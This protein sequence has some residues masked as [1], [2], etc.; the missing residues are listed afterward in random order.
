[1]DVKRV[2]LLSVTITFFALCFVGIVMQVLAMSQLYFAYKITSTIKIA[3]PETIEPQALSVCTRYTDVIDFDKLNNETGRNWNYT[4]YHVD[5]K[6]YQKELTIAEIMRYTPSKMLKET[7]FRTSGSYDIKIINQNGEANDHFIVT[8]YLYLEFICYRY[9]LKHATTESYDFYGVTIAM[10]GFIWGLWIQLTDSTMARSEIIKVSIH[11]P[12]SYPY[13]SLKAIA[14]LG[15][16]YNDMLKTS[17]YNMY[18]SDQV[19]LTAD[20]LPSPYESDCFD[21]NVLGFDDEV[22]CRQ[23]CVKHKMMHRYKKIPFSTITNES[24]P[25]RLVSYDDVIDVKFA[26]AWKQMEQECADLQCRQ[27]GC[28]LRTELT[29]TIFFSASDM[30]FFFNAPV[31]PWIKINTREMMSL[32]EFLTYIMGTIGVWTGLSIVSLE[33]KRLQRRLRKSLM[34]RTNYSNVGPT[35]SE[36]VLALRPNVI[37]E[38]Q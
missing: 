27:P 33:P 16:K 7:M 5:I 32:V 28:I 11:R 21:Y 12:D 3:I 29:K 31:D 1:M 26:A 2:L 38:S 24:S 36:R 19:Q 35:T 15:R 6:K 13:R 18:V 4:L 14:G 10:P 20:L 25:D 8:K 22:H 30:C 9:V 37:E 23:Q 34:K 17:A